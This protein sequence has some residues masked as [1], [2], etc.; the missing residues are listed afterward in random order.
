[1]TTITETTDAAASTSTTYAMGV[2]DVF[3]G[4]LGTPSDQDWVRVELAAGQSIEVLMTGTGGGLT[5]GQYCHVDLFDQSGNLLVGEE[6][7]G[8]DF[9]YLDYTNTTGVAQTVYIKT[10][11][12][13]SAV[14]GTYT[15]EVTTPP[16]HSPLD[17]LDWGGSAVPSTNVTVYFAAAGEVFDGVTSLGWTQ[18][19]IDNVMAALQDMTKGTN[20]TF[21]FTTNSATA[22]FKMVTENNP[23]ES[24]SA[25]MN[26]PI[27][28]NPGVGVFNTANMNL[29]SLIQGS[30]DYFII[31]HE[32]GHAL[33]LSHP[34][35]TGGGS[36]IMDGVTNP[37]DDLG[38]YNLNQG[39]YTIM[40]YNPGYYEL[41]NSWPGTYGATVG[42]MAFDLA[43]LQQKYGVSAA[44]TGNT[45]YN[46]PGTNVNGTFF[47][48][49]WDT[50][51][52]D[53]IR[54]TGALDA[55]ISLVA[56]TLDYSKTGGGV[57]SFA[58][59]IKGG[60]TIANGVV[61]E[62]ATGGSGDD[63]I[64]GNGAANI[65]KGNAGNDILFGA[66][67]TGRDLLRGG[68]DSDWL[69][70]FGDGDLQ[71]ES[72]MDIFTGASGTK[73]LDYV[74]GE[75]IVF[76]ANANTNFSRTGNDILVNGVRV[77]GGYLVDTITTYRPTTDHSSLDLQYS[78]I[79]DLFLDVLQGMDTLPGIFGGV[80]RTQY[81]S[82]ENN[83]W[84]TIVDTILGNNVIDFSW[85]Y[86][87]AGQTYYALK[88]DFDQG[89]AANWTKIDFYYKVA[90][91]LD[92]KLTTYDAGES[93]HSIKTD[94]DQDG[95]LTWDSIVT[96]Y[97]AANIQDFRWTYYDSGQ[98]YYSAKTDYDQ[99]G[100]GNWDN[101]VY[102]YAAAGVLD[103]KWTYY[104]AGQ[105]FF[106]IKTDYDQA[107][108]ETWNQILT[109]YKTAGVVD[110]K[111]TY[112]DAGEPSYAKKTDYD[113]DG[114]YTWD[115]IDTYYSAPNVAD[116][117]W[118]FYDAG[119]PNYAQ[120]IDYDQANLY[121]WDQHVTVYS[122]P[123]VV[124]NDYYV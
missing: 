124:A 26:P 38:D 90:G 24:Y 105:P 94:Y 61:I 101:I 3:N 23:G 17:A 36:T 96:Y 78:L 114:L 35:D 47:S 116:Y 108:G 79:M 91:S 45:V 21:T 73:I 33:G 69:F 110:L 100:T 5:S 57:V 112:Y 40:S 53:E 54:Y 70:D 52:T 31:Q 82:N 43:L 39:V 8:A 84:R 119:Q 113:Q 25:Y 117:R 85:I 89:M 2:G 48:T 102:N 46:L 30:I 80:V 59:G 32:A 123:G 15:V 71:G 51:G 109:Y 76:F 106:V 120:K 27:V 60:F 49:I 62:N 68:L 19:Q 93:F 9:S 64:F 83:T 72:G 92:W 87:D 67:G 58:S 65:L 88:T 98:A 74:N 99:G 11:S 63:R 1:M 16:P 103:N 75:A 50:G 12:F 77:V 56:A 20:L 29:N 104:D 97:S 18:T 44:N 118:T 66:T 4:S 13:A 28:A 107:S 86:Y 115:S 6:S 37:W 42:P 55:F 95:T 122:A 121:W 34:H 7:F 41:Y 10:S 14:S 81:D 111:W 22:T